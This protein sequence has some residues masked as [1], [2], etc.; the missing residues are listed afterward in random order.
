[1]MTNT[2]TTAKR[3]L[4]LMREL[5]A[6]H[7]HEDPSILVTQV[8]DVGQQMIE[9]RP[10]G[11]WGIVLGVVIG[12]WMPTS[13]TAVASLMRYDAYSSSLRSCRASGCEY[14]PQSAACDSRDCAQ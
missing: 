5:L 12:C 1:M 6:M 2:L 3:T 9:A 14:G 10:Q 8:K 11:E 13:C 7:R 4:E